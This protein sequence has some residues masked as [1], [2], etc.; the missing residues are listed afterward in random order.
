MY[1]SLHYLN[2]PLIDVFRTEFYPSKATPHQVRCEV[3]MS[4]IHGS[5]GL[6]YFVHEWEPK[7]NEFAL[8]SDPAMLLAVTAINRQIIALAPVLNSA[9][10]KDGARVSS[11]NKGVP[12]A[13][14]MKRHP[15]RFACS[16]ASCLP[17]RL[18]SGD[19]GAG[20]ANRGALQNRSS[21]GRRI[22][23]PWGCGTAGQLRRSPCPAWRAPLE[24]PQ[25][26][27]NPQKGRFLTGPDEENAC[28]NGDFAQIFPRQISVR[29]CE[30]GSY[31]FLNNLIKKN[32]RN[33]LKKY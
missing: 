5:M 13:V 12:V 14:M 2:E 23:L 9:T 24:I 19:A 27:P 15:R 1:F 6:I 18:A 11:D 16:F 25:V 20:E 26:G 29:L 4:I 22:F 10:I 17:P 21:G 7:F 8:L 33:L 31:T 30:Q 28:S 32:M 3:W